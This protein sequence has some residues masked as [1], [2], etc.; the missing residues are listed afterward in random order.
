[1]ARSIKVDEILEGQSHTRGHEEEVM[2]R[3][4]EDVAKRQTS[5]RQELRHTMRRAA[6]REISTIIKYGHLRYD[7]GLG[8]LCRG[9]DEIRDSMSRHGIGK[10]IPRQ[11]PEKEK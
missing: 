3:Y 1:M 4:D 9:C 10:C 8:Y 2:G 7:F 11:E 6:L 5:E